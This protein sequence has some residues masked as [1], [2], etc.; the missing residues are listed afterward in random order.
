VLKKHPTKKPKVF[1]FNK[2][3]K[4]ATILLKLYKNRDIIYDGFKGLPKKEF[5]DGGTQK[6]P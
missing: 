6:C 2:I 3:D 4:V 5:I 1:S